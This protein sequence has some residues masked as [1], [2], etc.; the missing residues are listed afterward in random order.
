[1]KLVFAL[2]VTCALLCSAA[3]ASPASGY[4]LYYLDKSRNV[5][6]IRLDSAG[7]P[8]GEP[9]RLT[10]L[11]GYDYYSVSPDGKWVVGLREIGGNEWVWKCFLERPGLDP[12][13]RIFGIV[14]SDGPPRVRWSGDG[15]YLFCWGGQIDGTS[16][17]YSLA[18]KKQIYESHYHFGPISYDGRYAFSLR[19]IPE[20]E[21]PARL[22]IIDV[23][24]GKWASAAKVLA[25]ERFEY[26]CLWIGRTHEFALTDA[27]GNVWVGSVKPGKLRHA[28]RK[29]ALTTRGGC[30]DP[31]YIPGKGLFFVQTLPG[32]DPVA[33]CS[34]DLKT[35]NKC[36]QML[37][38]EENAGSGLEVWEVLPNVNGLWRWSARFSPDRRYI[39]CLL[40]AGHNKMPEILVFDRQGRYHSVGQGKVLTWKGSDET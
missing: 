37:S 12:I 18:A 17:V 34:Q 27:A 26:P 20:E 38:S 10:S 2:S 3:N 29:R 14:D 31:Q 11:G 19:D 24:S 23:Q 33:Y 13:G 35:L 1:M 25:D 9:R 7:K 39:A 28:V 6:E 8:A 32:R 30:S 40:D 36:P 16:R 4:T 15:K 21:A 5:C 22:R